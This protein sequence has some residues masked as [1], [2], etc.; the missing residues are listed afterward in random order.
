M[1]LDFGR[2]ICHSELPTYYVYSALMTT[3]HMLCAISTSITQSLPS[4]HLVIAAPNLVHV[5][6]ILALCAVLYGAANDVTR[7][8]PIGRR[9][10]CHASQERSGG[11]LFTS[12]VRGVWVYFK[13]CQTEPSTNWRNAT[14]S[15]RLSPT[16]V[17]LLRCYLPLINSRLPK[18]LC[19]PR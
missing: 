15:S 2:P 12:V 17:H 19:A 6:P 3:V 4:Y 8:P 9:Y 5:K 7:N 14:A 18:H 11:F 13:C 1:S 10:I 16:S